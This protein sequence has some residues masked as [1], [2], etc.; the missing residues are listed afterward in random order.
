[1]D[2]KKGYGVM[3]SPSYHLKNSPQ[4]NSS[5][6]LWKRQDNVKQQFLKN[7]RSFDFCYSLSSEGV[8]TDDVLTNT[9]VATFDPGTSTGSILSVIPMRV[10]GLIGVLG[11]EEGRERYYT[12]E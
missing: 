2:M 3:E 4:R 7:I 8:D 11:E 9:K 12:L 1:V 6:R 10:W 5:I